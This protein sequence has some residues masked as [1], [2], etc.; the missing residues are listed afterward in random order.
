M[1]GFIA[2]ELYLLFLL[3]GTCILLLLCLLLKASANRRIQ[4]QQKE[5]CGDNLF[6]FCYTGWSTDLV[7]ALHPRTHI[8][9]LE[10][11]P[12]IIELW[13]NVRRLIR[14]PVIGELMLLGDHEQ[15]SYQVGV[16]DQSRKLSFN[17]HRC[18]LRLLRSCVPLLGGLHHLLLVHLHQIMSCLETSQILAPNRW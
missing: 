7:P 11:H 13:S 8:R 6:V 2:S 14:G 16:P 12:W 18:Q 10:P 15:M 4:P 5:H 17:E 3:D 9:K 1:V